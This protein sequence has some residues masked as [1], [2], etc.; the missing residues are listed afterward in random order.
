L[1]KI[2]FSAEGRGRVGLSSKKYGFDFE[3]LISRDK[4]KWSLDFHFPAGM[5]R[6]IEVDYDRPLNKQKASF[7]KLLAELNQEEFNDWL[8]G[9]FWEKMSKILKAQ[10]ELDSDL[11]WKTLEGKFLITFPPEKGYF[12]RFEATDLDL[13]Y[14]RIKI[15]IDSDN[16]GFREP[17]LQIDLYLDNCSV[18]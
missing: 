6:I 7:K 14:K 18:V 16:R 17:P 1:E 15:L 4:K 2:C 9:E 12:F 3:S 5:E 13:F 11:S 10:E 8:L